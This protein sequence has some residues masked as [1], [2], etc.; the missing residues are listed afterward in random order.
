MTEEAKAQTLFVLGGKSG[1][2]KTTVMNAAAQKELGQ[3]GRF[4]S[5][6][7]EIKE[8][9]VN[10]KGVKYAFLDTIGLSDTREEYTNEKILKEIQTKM[11]L[12]PKET[13]IIFLLLQKLTA[14]RYYLAQEIREYMTI[15]GGDFLKNSIIIA[16]GT[17]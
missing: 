2:G 5:Q 10:R 17:D 14:E 11:S 3:T 8:H 9:I 1:Q 6:T 16:T 13:K 7:S 12:Y 15:F 4:K